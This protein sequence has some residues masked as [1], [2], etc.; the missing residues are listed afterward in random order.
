MGFSAAPKE[1][2]RSPGNET[3][4]G[5]NKTRIKMKYVENVKPARKQKKNQSI[6]MKW[7]TI[8]H[9]LNAQSPLLMCTLNLKYLCQY[10]KKK[11]CHPLKCFVMAGVKEACV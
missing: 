1:G 2:K 7:V 3:T 10:L 5:K 4:R 11:M 9:C 6:E 8:V